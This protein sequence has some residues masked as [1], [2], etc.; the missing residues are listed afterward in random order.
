M[1]EWSVDAKIECA[2]GPCGRCLTLIVDRETRQVTHLV[3][4]DESLPDQP[5]PRLVPVDRVAEADK[6][7]IRLSCTR[8]ELAQ[9]EPFIQTRYLQ[10]TGLRYSVLPPGETPPAGAPAAGV[11]YSTYEE[12]MV[13]EG[14][15]AIGPG[16]N[17]E[18]TDGHAGTVGELVVDPRTA[19]I[20]H[21]VLREGHRWGEKEVTLP[22]TAVDRV[23]GKTVYLRLDRQAIGQLPAIPVRRYHVRRED[24]VPRRMDLVAVVFDAPEDAGRALQF[25]DE[26]RK[27]GT[28]KLLNAAVLVKDAAG[29]VTVK[30]TRDIDPKKGRLLGAVTGGLIGLVGGPAGALA[31]ALTG[32]GAGGLA[33]KKID[34]GFSQPFLNGLQQYLQPNTS[35][36]VV[37]VE[38]GYYEQLSDVIAEEEGVFFH[39]TLTDKLVEQ[40]LAEGG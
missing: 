26:F 38:H 33:G 4:E 39:Q 19:E 23:A 7:L 3:V 40:L 36:L 13:P 1:S 24:E 11:A 10:K 15:V 29:N 25:I 5:H 6:D 21:F 17:V 9:M 16:L 14:A 28:L 31:G 34:L 22:L 37:L 32:A 20:T 8:D 12:E 30:D 35:A 27:K 2:D 18:A